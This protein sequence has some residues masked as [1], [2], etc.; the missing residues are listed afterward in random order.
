M[1]CWVFITSSL[2]RQQ[3]REVLGNSNP[4]LWGLYSIGLDIFRSHPRMDHHDVVSSVQ[5]TQYYGA[6]RNERLF[7][8]GGTY[9]SVG[10]SV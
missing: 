7:S 8:A 3:D 2:F 6:I 4:L 5:C 10:G 9:Q 1:I